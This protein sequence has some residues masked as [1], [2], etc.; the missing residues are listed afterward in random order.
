M[1]SR[2]EVSERDT[3][4]AKALSHPVRLQALKILD[5][6]VASPSEIAD[7][8]GLPVSNV[9]YH[10]RALLQLECIEEVA[11]RPVRGALEHL[12]RAVRRPA[13]A[14]DEWED[15]PGAARTQTAASVFRGTLADA[16]GSLEAGVFDRASERHLTRTE[17]EL[18]EESWRTLNDRLRALLDEALALQAASDERRGKTKATG[19]RKPAADVRVVRSTLSLLHFER[20]EADAAGG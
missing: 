2:Y 18:D 5:E 10:V 3:A 7:E 11:T 8:L 1:G 17:L 19:R 4:L 20:A 14:G 12:Y 9:A 6:R 15:I 13:I 16:R